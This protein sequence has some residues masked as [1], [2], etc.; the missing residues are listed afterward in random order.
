MRKNLLPPEWQ[1][2][3][4][5]MLT[6]PHQKTD[7]SANLSNIEAVYIKIS[8]AVLAQQ[9][10]VIVCYDITLKAHILKLLSFVNVD[11]GR[12]WFVI[13]KSNDCW[14]RD[15]G[16]ISVINEQGEVIALNFTFNGWGKKFSYKLDNKINEALFQQL[17]INTYQ[18]I[19]MVLEG[20]SIET[21]GRGNLLTTRHCL[22]NLNRNP[23]FSQKEVEHKLK[24]YFGIK[25]VLWLNH[26]SLEGDDTDSHIDTLA[27][28]TPNNGIVYQ[29]CRDED[30]SH[31]CELKLMKHAL[32]AM[33]GDF[34]LIELPFP[35]AQFNAEG[36]RLP[37]SYANFLIINGAVLVPSYGV[38]QDKK[39]VEVLSLAF[40]EHKIVSIN[41]R[42]IIE[43]FGSLHCLTMQLPKGFLS[44]AN[45]ECHS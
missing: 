11:V 43:Q 15:H 29:G 36:A 28:F 6:W 12:I 45:G 20:G 17:N 5:V 16:P 33:Q 41:C 3:D 13:A 14:A 39:A 22:L 31:Y 4:A 24:A 44:S 34:N 10:L 2:Q 18:N 27:R 21:D 19:D 42:A 9:N 38:S 40:P 37:A 8:L 35:K 25:R 30:D 1:A 23:K 32:M 26:G 7:W